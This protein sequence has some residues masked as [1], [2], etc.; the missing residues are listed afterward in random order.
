MD[1]KNKKKRTNIGKKAKKTQKRDL[2]QNKQDSD[3]EQE[4]K[5]TKTIN[6]QNNT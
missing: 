5:K 1:K 3:L 6:S 4:S 2:K